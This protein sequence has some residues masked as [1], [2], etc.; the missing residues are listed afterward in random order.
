MIDYLELPRQGVHSS[1]IKA[2]AH[3]F[4]SSTLVVEFHSGAI[5]KYT[6][7]TRKGF[8]LLI[9]SESKGKFFRQ[10]IRENSSITAE[11]IDV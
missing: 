9:S 5:W 11:R 10:H 2:V 4:D 8:D 3:D 6:P 7:V 1:H